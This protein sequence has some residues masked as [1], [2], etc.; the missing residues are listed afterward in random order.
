MSRSDV[1]AVRAGNDARDGHPRPPFP[2]QQQS[3]PGDD[4]RLDPPPDHGEATYV[5]SGRLTGLVTVVTGAD[6][7]I[8]K[9]VAIAFAREGADVVVSYLPRDALRPSEPSPV[10]GSPFPTGDDPWRD[11]GSVR[12]PRGPGSQ[13]ARPLPTFVRDARRGYLR[14]WGLIAGGDRRR[15]RP[16]WRRAPDDRPCRSRSTASCRA[17]AR[18]PA[19]CSRRARGRSG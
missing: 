12:G 16:P 5:S 10:R 8:G 9:S 13:P 3:L 1:M 2:L 6:S 14:A 17:R 19:P 4:D 15:G 18:P 7:G 11:S